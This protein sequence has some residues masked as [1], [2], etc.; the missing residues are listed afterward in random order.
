M[1]PRVVSHV[2]YALLLATGACAADVTSVEPAPRTFVSQRVVGDAL[3]AKHFCTAASSNTEQWVSLHRVELAVD[4]GD[5]FVITAIDEQGNAQFTINDAG[6]KTYTAQMVVGG[7]RSVSGTLLPAQNGI[8]RLEFKAPA[9]QSVGDEHVWRT[10]R[11]HGASLRR[12]RDR[13]GS[14]ALPDDGRH[15][16]FVRVHGDPQVAHPFE[17]RSRSALKA[18]PLGDRARPRS[19]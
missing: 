4:R 19:F 16:L 13:D 15:R 17:L 2:R 3:P 1:R 12:F 18:Q 5:G 14:G 9:E 6:V 10:G 8:R 7:A 11:L